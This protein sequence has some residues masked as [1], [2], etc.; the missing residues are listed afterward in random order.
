MTAGRGPGAP[1]FT[2]EDLSIL[3]DFATQAALALEHARLYDEATRNAA[4]YQALF[5]VSGVVSSTLEVDRVLDLVVERCRALLGVAGLGIF[6][7]DHTTG[8]VIYERGRGLSPQFM[9]SRGVPLGEGTTGRAV[10]QREPVWSE[11]VLNDPAVPISPGT[12]AEIEREGYRSVLS[13][14]LLSKG[15]VLGAVAAYWW[16]PHTPS[17]AELSVMTALAGQAAVALDNARMFAG[18]RDRK[19]SLTSLLEINKKIGALASPETLLASIAEEAA[20]LL[21]VD[22]AV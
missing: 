4:Q 11:D 20:R 1:P 3:S 15:Q 21:G 7:F 18:E 17:P 10:E 19:A 16:E 12:R 22:N 5:E 8:L 14:P 2:E 13:V 9:R 6:R